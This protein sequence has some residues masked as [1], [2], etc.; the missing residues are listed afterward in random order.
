MQDQMTTREKLRLQAKRQ[1]WTRGYSSVSVRQIAKAAG[2][3]VALISR[4]FGGKRGIFEATIEDAFNVFDEPP[5]TEQDLIDLFVTMFKDAPRSDA[6]PSAVRMLLMNAHD[7][8]VGTL[9]R[10]QYH[11]QFHAHLSHILVDQQRAAL[12]MAVLFGF[13]VVEKSL[14]IEG[15]APPKSPAYE[16]QLRYMIDAALT[17]APA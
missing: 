2:V 11:D 12:L 13:S 1:F 6:D 9:V 7:E 8:T 5:R 10:Q 15:I 17:F 14:H 4:Y 3:D 16:A